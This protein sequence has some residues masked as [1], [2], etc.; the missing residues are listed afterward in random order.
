MFIVGAAAMTIYAPNDADGDVL[1]AL[2]EDGFDFS[3]KC[4]I[5]FNVEFESWP[6]HSEAM[7]IL[8]KKYPNIKLCKP[9]D[10]YA[11]YVLVQIQDLLSYELVTRVQAE[12]TNL[13]KPYGGRCDSWG[14]MT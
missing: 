2:E 8:S 3:E 11:G 6:P 14:V 9:S 13:M 12:I 10:E 4:L 5:D 7:S 1:R